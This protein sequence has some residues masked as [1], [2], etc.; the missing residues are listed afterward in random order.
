MSTTP[1]KSPV[2]ESELEREA[3][4]PRR[5]FFAEMLGYLASPAAFWIIPIVVVL[6]MVGLLLLLQTSVVAPFIYPLF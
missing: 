2:A 5:S 1:A 4:A 3:A 6:L